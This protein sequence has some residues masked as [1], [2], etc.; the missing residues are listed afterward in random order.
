MAASEKS[1]SLEGLE[2][3]IDSVT[4]LFLAVWDKSEFLAYFVIVMAVIFPFWVVFAW[5]VAN[6]PE[7]RIDRIVDKS[8]KTSKQ[9]IKGHNGGSKK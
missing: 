5:L 8:R 2:K 7:R 1:F 6:K 9:R 3:I 4:K